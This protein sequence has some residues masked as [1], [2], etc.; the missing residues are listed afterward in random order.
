MMFVGSVPCG[1]FE[2]YDEHFSAYAMYQ[3]AEQYFCSND[4]IATTTGVTA[5]SIGKPQTMYGTRQRTGD[6]F[7]FQSVVLGA[8]TLGKN[9][10]GAMQRFRDENNIVSY[11]HLKA[12]APRRRND[13][14]TIDFDKTEWTTCTP[15]EYISKW[16]TSPENLVPFN[17]TADTPSKI[18]RDENGN[19]AATFY[20]DYQ[21]AKDYAANIKASSNIGLKSG[22][23]SV[24]ITFDEN[25]RAI[26][27]TEQS[28][29][30]MN[31]FTSPTVK[32]SITETIEYKSAA[33]PSCSIG[34]FLYKY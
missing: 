7:F 22:N 13:I 29:Y 28:T 31:I 30:K 5:P 34:E 17:I 14:V 11:R 6:Q 23:F 2:N 20:V 27:I 33:L 1:V 18:S 21:N 26:K 4:F 15:A 25:A 8:S 3:Y 9:P 32:A 19:V 24:T 10:S 12:K 16:K